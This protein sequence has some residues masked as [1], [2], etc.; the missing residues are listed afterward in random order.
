MSWVGTI[1]SSI[2]SAILAFSRGFFQEFLSLV[3]WLGAIILSYYF[4]KYF[5]DILDGMIGNL[6]ISKIGQIE[7]DTCPFPLPIKG[8]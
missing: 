5:V 4:S 1:I 8:C 7:I 2:L 6:I 3:S